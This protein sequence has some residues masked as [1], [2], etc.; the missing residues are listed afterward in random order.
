VLNLHYRNA[1]ADPPAAEARLAEFFGNEWFDASAAAA[2]VDPS[3]SRTGR[4]T[5]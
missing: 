5:Q 2:A 3:L 1:V 4:E